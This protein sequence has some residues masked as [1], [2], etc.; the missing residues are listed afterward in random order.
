[1]MCVGD[2]FNTG[3]LFYTGTLVYTGIG[4]DEVRQLVVAG[5]GKI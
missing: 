1:M 5:R 4:V 3:T 2:L